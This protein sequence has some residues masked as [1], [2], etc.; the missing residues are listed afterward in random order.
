MKDKLR[1]E[2]LGSQPLWNKQNNKTI[3]TSVPQLIWHHKFCIEIF[4]LMLRMC[5]Q[6]ELRITSC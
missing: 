5:G 3:T 2:I 6:L 1:L 4:T